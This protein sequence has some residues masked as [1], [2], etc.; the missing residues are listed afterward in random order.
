[1]P[2]QNDEGAGLP[3]LAATAAAVTLEARSLRALVHTH[4]IVVT[5]IA[6]AT[7]PGVTTPEAMVAMEGAV[8]ME[9]DIELR[10]Q[11][12]FGKFRVSRLLLGHHRTHYKNKD[13]NG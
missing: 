9:V 13:T 6:E 12:Y 10:S 4:T 1:M 11:S 5:T 7:T 3:H 2:Q 8:V